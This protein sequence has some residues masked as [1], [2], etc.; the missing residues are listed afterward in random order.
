VVF[1]LC[2]FYNEFKNALIYVS[3]YFGK[4]E[5]SGDVTQLAQ[6]QLRIE[7]RV[8]DSQNNL[9]NRDFTANLLQS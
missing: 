5:G 9:P 3:N 4:L 7:V 2:K 1:R 8:S 6:I